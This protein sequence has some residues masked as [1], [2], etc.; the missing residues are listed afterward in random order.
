MD[1]ADTIRPEDH[2]RL[3]TWA[4]RRW[5]RGDPEEDW[6]TAA[7]ALMEA[8]R[9]YQATRGS[10]SNW[11]AVCLHHALRSA[12][13]RQQRWADREWLWVDAPIPSPTDGDPETWGAMQPDPVDSLTRWWWQWSE[14]DWRDLARRVRAAGPSVWRL[15]VDCLR[16]PEASMAERARRL[17][18]TPQNAYYC[19]QRLRAV[20][21]AGMQEQLARSA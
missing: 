1:H 20:L 4:V 8:A 19:R 16:W 7:V 6:G 15:F 3:V 14:Y 21:W 2:L 13:E 18:W 17:G 10:W 5:G 12:A 9:T 11:A